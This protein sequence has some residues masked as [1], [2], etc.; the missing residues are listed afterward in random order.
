ME[1]LT[2]KTSKAVKDLIIINND[3]YE[4][5]KLAADKTKNS[6]LKEV[7]TKYA[8]QSQQFGKELETLLPEK[9]YT[10]APLETRNTGKLYRVWM[11]IKN[12]L[13]QNNEH[14]LLAS[15][16]FGEDTAKKTYDEVLQ[17]PGDVSNEILTVIRSQR[18]Q[19]QQAHDK[20]KSLRDSKKD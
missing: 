8:S 4:G 7:F 20:I 3:R 12:A 5:Y 19:L 1:T 10:P 9:K 15:C 17:K 14:S 13:S 16:E 11:D 2:E 6:S 18:E